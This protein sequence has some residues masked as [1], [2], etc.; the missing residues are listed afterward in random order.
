M[1]EDHKNSAQQKHHT[2]KMLT[3]T[4]AGLVLSLG[5]LA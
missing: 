5:M 3:V 1:E 4:S 2:E